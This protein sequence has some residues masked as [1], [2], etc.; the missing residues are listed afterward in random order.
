[1]KKA[2]SHDPMEPKMVASVD[3]DGGSHSL[4][5]NDAH[6]CSLGEADLKLYKR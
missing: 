2:I 3:L 6:G 5:Y 4:G 1:M